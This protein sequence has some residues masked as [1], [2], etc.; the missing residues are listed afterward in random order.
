MHIA[1]VVVQSRP[2]NLAAVQRRLQQVAGVEVHAVNPDGRFVVTI[3]DDHRHAVADRMYQLNA[4]EGVL[5]AFVVYE[6]SEFTQAEAS[7]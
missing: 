6:E 2:E 3:E 5:S 7:Q 4:L 1:G